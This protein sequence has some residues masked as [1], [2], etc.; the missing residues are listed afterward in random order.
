ME[1]Q[2]KLKKKRWSKERRNIRVGGVKE[3]ERQK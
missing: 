1:I 2:F 3:T